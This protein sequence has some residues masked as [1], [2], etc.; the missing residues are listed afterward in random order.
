MYSII[1]NCRHFIISQE[2]AGK[3]YLVFVHGFPFDHTVWEKQWDQRPAGMNY[4]AYD[5]RGF[6]A[7][8]VG[9][10]QYTME[11]FADDLLEIIHRHC[12]G[13]AIVCGLSMGGYVA[14]RALEKYPDAFSGIILCG[15]KADSEEDKG[16]LARANTL[17]L[18]KQHGLSIYTDNT[19]GSLFGNKTKSRKPELVDFIRKIIERQNPL[20]VCGGIL[21]MAARTN[22][23]KG[24]NK[25]TQPVLIMTGEEDAISG[26]PY[27]K[28]MAEAANRATL[29]FISEAGHLCHLEQYKTFNSQL[30]GWL[31]AHFLG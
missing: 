4:L 16:K 22:T 28:E 14:L 15:T 3:P 31:N 2:E 8:D 13:E 7:S 29:K 10:G 24:L 19:I 18:V 11:M 21:A 1:N 17:K 5:I 30:E 23:L 26:E 9:D 27:A 20:A 12:G 6:G 25:F